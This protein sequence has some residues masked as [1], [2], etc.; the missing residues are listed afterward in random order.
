VSP[1]LQEEEVL[2][3]E[4]KETVKFEPLV[5]IDTWKRHIAGMWGTCMFFNVA[6]SVAD[7]EVTLR[8]I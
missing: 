8:S 4:L 2:A 6:G 3:G 5:G 1:G 7:V